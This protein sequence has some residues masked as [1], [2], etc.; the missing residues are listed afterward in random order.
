MVCGLSSPCPRYRACCWGRDIGRTACPRPQVAALGRRPASDRRRRGVLAGGEEVCMRPIA[1]SWAPGL[2]ARDAVVVGGGQAGLALGHHLA[3]GGSGSSSS[4]PPI[5]RDRPG[6]T[7]GTGCG[8][9][10][11]ASTTD[12]PA[13]P[14]R[15]P[16]P[17]PRHSRG[18]GPP[19]RVRRRAG[20][21]GAVGSTCAAGDPRWG[22]PAR[23]DGG[24]D[25]GRRRRGAG[26]RHVHG[27]R[28]PRCLETAAARLHPAAQQRLPA[29]G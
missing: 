16:G 15:A 2:P 3:A 14:S 21:P 25:A 7:G 27:S 6:T 10:P 26:H 12:C 28:R 4:T 18:R 22:R 11:P 13:G 29:A 1:R 5:G 23:R 9:S 19:T 17:L 20:A 24:R 8:C